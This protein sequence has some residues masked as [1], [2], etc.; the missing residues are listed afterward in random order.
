MAG[1]AGDG[2][3]DRHAGVPS[4][5]R[6]GLSG[7]PPRSELGVDWA[8]RYAPAALGAL[9]EGFALWV[10]GQN[11]ALELVHRA[12]AAMPVEGGPG[13]ALAEGVGLAGLLERVRVGG[14]PV[15]VRAEDPSLR[16]R[17][18]ALP[19]GA[20]GASWLRIDPVAEA[21]VGAAGALGL[22]AVELERLMHTLSS[23]EAA[24]LDDR[25]VLQDGRVGLARAQW[26]LRGLAQAVPPAPPLRLDR[27]LERLRPALAERVPEHLELRWAVPEALPE[28]RLSSGMIGFL[29]HELVM[30]AVNALE[31]R[32]PM[33][34]GAEGGAGC[35]LISG[36]LMRLRAP[37]PWQGLPLSAGS[38]AFLEV[39]D[40]G[41]G[42]SG[43][44]AL[45]PFG[46][47]EK[48]GLGLPAIRGL[49]LAVGGGVRLRSVAGRG[50]VV[51]LALP[52]ATPAEQAVRLLLID[53]PDSNELALLNAL[54][55]AGLR[56]APMDDP[57]APS[58]GLLPVVACAR[59]PSDPRW[60]E[61][62]RLV[63]A[64]T[65]VPVVLW[66]P[67]NGTV[68]PL[69]TSPEDPSLEIVRDRA[70]GAAVAAVRRML[71]DAPPS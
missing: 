43:P 48:G 27:A 57:D 2:P 18:C 15:W 71:R 35:V 22:V 68:R 61:V 3:G 54:G 56:V 9:H 12:G 17:L 63:H 28:V 47:R 19:D 59:G 6:V 49:M 64:D 65:G 8:A 53:E 39:V 46:L 58:G 45:D 1:G 44:S 7:A 10:P 26:R 55:A 67:G 60:R 25:A 30:N 70:P 24:T 11:G 51:Q 41:P 14:P 21:G 34:S 31:T 38:Y 37:R 33:Q 32:H 40:D 29:L 69:E 13:V 5:L 36:G 20:V 23:V 50:T 4:L 66:A 52:V 16:A 62:E 42:F